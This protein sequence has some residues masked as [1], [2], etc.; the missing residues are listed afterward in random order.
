MIYSVYVAYFCSFSLLLGVLHNSDSEYENRV[1]TD[2]DTEGIRHGQA[3]EA[4]Q[5]A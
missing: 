4:D 1:D 2:I 3:Y 5:T